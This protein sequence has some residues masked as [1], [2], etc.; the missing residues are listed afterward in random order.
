MANATPEGVGE[1]AEGVSPQA[2]QR[3]CVGSRG[4]PEQRGRD[5]DIME[6]ADYTVHTNAL[7]GGSAASCPCR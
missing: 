7:A 2:Q 6:D 1:R 3:Q 5:S 4:L